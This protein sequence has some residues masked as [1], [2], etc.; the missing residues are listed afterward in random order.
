[1]NQKIAFAQYN[2]IDLDTTDKEFVLRLRDK[3]LNKAIKDDCLY[4]FNIYPS[5]RKGYHI[6]LYC[7][8]KCDLCR[9]VF[10][11]DTRYFYDQYREEES[12]NVLTQKTERF[13]LM[14]KK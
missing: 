7:K 3:I 14:L 5:E 8:K 11:D 10:D 2:T 12:R 4:D 1:M 9:L 13:K 6:Q